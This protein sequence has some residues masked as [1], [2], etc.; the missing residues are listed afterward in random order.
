MESKVGPL[1]AGRRGGARQ[2]RLRTARVLPLCLAAVATSAVS[3]TFAASWNLLRSGAFAP[4]TRRSLLG[5]RDGLEV[6][7]SGALGSDIPVYEAP[8]PKSY[9]LWHDVGLYDKTWLDE[10]TGLYRFVNEMPMG[11]LQKFEVQPDLELNQMEEDLKGT[12]RLR[13]F[14]RPVPFNYGCFPQTWRDP[15]IQ[16]SIHGAGGDDD[17]LDVFDLSY[18]TQSVGAIVTVRALGAVCLIDE[19]QADWKILAI[20]VEADEPLASAQSIEDVERI[21]PGRIQDTLKWIDDFKQSSRKEGD[22]NVKLHFEIH[23][24]MKA[25]ELIEGDH[26]SWARLVAETDEHGLSHGHWIK[27]AAAAPAGLPTRRAPARLMEAKR[28]MSA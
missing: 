18:T 4:R 9:S 22:E 1:I 23:D 12:K 24:A 13:A 20:N 11:A 27:H 25:V 7:G 17:P 14:G 19:G 16:D 8:V 21:A 2:L 15:E 3:S 28:M 6:R 10:S 26:L 5:G